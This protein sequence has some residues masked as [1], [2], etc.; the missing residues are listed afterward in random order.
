MFQVIHTRYDHEEGDPYGKS[1]FFGSR[2]SWRQLGMME[3]S[4]VI[5]R[6]T[7]TSKRY[8]YHIPI[9]K[10]ITP[11]DRRKIIEEHKREL[12]KNK[13]IDT[14]GKFNIKRNPLADNEDI[15]MPTY[16]DNPSKVE[17]LDRGGFEGTLDDIKYIQTKV[18]MPTKVPKA[19]MGLEADVRSKA[20]LSWQDVEFAR[21][22]RSIQKLFASFQRRVLDLQLILLGIVPEEGLYFIVY[23]AISFVDEKVKIAIQQIKWQIAVSAKQDLGIPTEW[24]LRNVVG[25]DDQAVNDI[26]AMGI[27]EPVKVEPNPDQ[28]KK[29]REAVMQNMQLQSELMDLKYMLQTISREKLNQPVEL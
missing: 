4:L 6:L 1:F 29:A 13:L 9:D 11:V 14:N 19:Y 18:I 10:G 12:K 3:D 22:I 28:K 5:N 16:P 27:E 23:P 20:T 7:K 2:R 25:L 17:L 8:V 24:L 26:L 15:F 21:M